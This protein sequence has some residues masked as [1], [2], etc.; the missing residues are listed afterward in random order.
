MADT[1]RL[2]EVKNQSK[3]QSTEALFFEVVLRLASEKGNCDEEIGKFLKSCR[4]YISHASHPPDQ[5]N[6]CF[7]ELKPLLNSNRNIANIYKLDPYSAQKSHE[8]YL[9]DELVS[10]FNRETTDKDKGPTLLFIIHLLA[11]CVPSIWINFICDKLRIDKGTKKRLIDCAKKN[12]DRMPID[13]TGFNWNY[14]EDAD[15]GNNQRVKN[16]NRFF[17][18]HGWRLLFPDDNEPAKIMIDGEEYEIARDSIQIRTKLDSIRFMASGNG[19]EEVRF[20]MSRVLLQQILMRQCLE[21]KNN[22]GQ[23]SCALSPAQKDDSTEKN[24]PAYK[25]KLY[26]YYKAWTNKKQWIAKDIQD[27]D[28]ADRHKATRSLARYAIREHNAIEGGLFKTHNHKLSDEQKKE[29]SFEKRKLY[30]ELYQFL[31]KEFD[32]AWCESRPIKLKAVVERP[33]FKDAGKNPQGTWVNKIDD[34]RFPDVFKDVCDEQLK[35]LDAAL[36]ARFDKFEEQRDSQRFNKF[37]T[38]SR[39]GSITDANPLNYK[40]DWRRIQQGGLRIYGRYYNAKNQWRQLQLLSSQT[41]YSAPPARH[42]TPGKIDEI[43][44]KLKPMD[45]LLQGVPIKEDLEKFKEL[46]TKYAENCKEKNKFLPKEKRENTRTKKDGYRAL[47]LALL[48]ITMHSNKEY[49][50]VIEKLV[51]LLI[52]GNSKGKLYYQLH[53]QF[54]CDLNSDWLQLYRGTKNMNADRVFQSFIDKAEYEKCNLSGSKF[55]RAFYGCRKETDAGQEVYVLDNNLLREWLKFNM[56]NMDHLLNWERS[57][58]EQF[59]DG[60]REKSDNGDYVRFDKVCDI[61]VNNSLLPDEDK[62]TLKCVR[63]GLAHLDLLPLAKVSKVVNSLKKVQK[64]G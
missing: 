47:E 46:I 32:L 36:K 16:W 63:K 55:S 37:M 17:M 48:I 64:S 38:G 61:A 12:N 27:T 31:Q 50:E 29:D 44:N 20:Q 35:K 59:P 24:T 6:A 3:N 19:Q 40:E 45:S 8:A 22:G 39:K 49:K 53:N 43:I 42:V 28:K 11:S 60:L 51:R 26:S 62:E 13:L 2:S 30:H 54:Y 14:H 41:E 25:E 56:T 52:K 15:Q 57:I 1:K 18:H 10:F 5:V 21:D 33:V 23:L 34:K 58:L 4:N 7:D 9:S